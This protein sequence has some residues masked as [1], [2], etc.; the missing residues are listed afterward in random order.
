[1]TTPPVI[2]AVRRRKRREYEE[3][4][5]PLFIRKASESLGGR[6]E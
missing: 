3:V 2:M 6:S 5:G 4:T 1:M